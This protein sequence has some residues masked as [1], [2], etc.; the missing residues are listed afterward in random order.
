M[1]FDTTVFSLTNIFHVFKSW[2]L[3]FWPDSASDIWVTF[4]ILNGHRN[5][6]PNAPGT[7]FDQLRLTHEHKRKHLAWICAS[8]FRRRRQGSKN[9]GQ[10]TES[11]AF[12]INTSAATVSDIWV[13]QFPNA[14]SLV[15][16][17]RDSR[18]DGLTRGMIYGPFAHPKLAMLA[19][20]GS[21]QLKSSN[22]RWLPVRL[23]FRVVSI[24]R[25]WYELFTSFLSEQAVRALWREANKVDSVGNFIWRV[26][27]IGDDWLR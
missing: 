21:V 12:R 7:Q 13:L 17:E 6:I 27:V 23:L 9:A 19:N 26:Y 24:V 16:T 2:N 4:E 14:G 3:L 10:L 11:N 1:Y 15:G 5:V 22:E 25:N 18:L 20:I 8:I